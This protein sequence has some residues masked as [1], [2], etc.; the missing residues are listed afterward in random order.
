MRTAK[1]SSKK[2]EEE[3]QVQK[4]RSEQEIAKLQKELR[5]MATV[6]V[7]ALRLWRR[8]EQYIYFFK[9]NTESK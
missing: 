9:F 8:I 1:E 4:E 6:S 5:K 7:K 2:L 3:L